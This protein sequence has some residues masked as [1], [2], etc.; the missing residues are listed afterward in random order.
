MEGL[1]SP[2]DRVATDIREIGEMVVFKHS[3]FA[4]PF[5]VISLVTA[6]APSWPTPAT[7]LWVTV[8]MVAART[9]AMA[10]NRL[11]DHRIDAD[12]PRTAGRALPA[13]RL[14]RGFAW[15]VTGLSAMV[16]VVAAAALNPL[17]L[18]L[19]PLTLAVLLGYSF[20]KR[21]TAAS[22]IWLGFAL[23]MAPIGA[24]IAITGRI[25]WQPVV[26]AGAVCLWVAGFDIIYSL[27]DEEFDR[28]HGL[29]S[30]PAR[31][32]GGTAL[33]V[34]RAAHGLAF[35]GFTVFAAAAGGGPLRLAAV[36]I[37][38]ALLAWQH[39]LVAADDLTAVDAAF[40][41]ANGTLA[42]MMAALFIVA[43]V[44]GS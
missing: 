31:L 22:H 28:I 41:S 29:H 43:R 27:Q 13:G 19:A 21:F 30:L 32:G 18:A 44:F 3:I 34:A 26:L 8:A 25:A 14:D 1:T 35:A 7:W 9:S 42:V 20:A 33:G 40:F 36:A 37:A 12:N 38:G 2:L 11:A 4:L 23:G 10:F 16:F 17:C 39:R 6:A 15:L 24:W 5:A